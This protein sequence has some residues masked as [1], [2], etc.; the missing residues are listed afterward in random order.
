MYLKSFIYLIIN[1]LKGLSIYDIF[2]FLHKKLLPVNLFMFVSYKTKFNINM[3]MNTYKKA[4]I[5]SNF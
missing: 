5:S 3:S 4:N 1:K 2:L